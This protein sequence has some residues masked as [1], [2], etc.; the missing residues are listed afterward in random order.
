MPTARLPCSQY[1]SSIRLFFCLMSYIRYMIENIF[2]FRHDVT[3]HATP[4]SHRA[5]IHWLS[6]T[7]RQKTD[8]H[9]ACRSIIP[10]FDPFSAA[11]R[12]QKTPSRLFLRGTCHVPAFIVSCFQAQLLSFHEGLQQGKAD[13][14]HNGG[15]DRWRRWPC[16]WPWPLPLPAA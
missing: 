1:K 3:G 9:F 16:H 15:P 12:H 4:Q 11:A 7:N 10:S 8:S 14:G 6:A 13:Q 2:C 5:G